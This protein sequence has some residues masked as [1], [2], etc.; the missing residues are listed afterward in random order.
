MYPPDFG[1][2]R[3]NLIPLSVLMRYGARH[4]F[5]ANGASRI[6]F[7]GDGDTDLRNDYVKDEDGNIVFTAYGPDQL[8]NTVK[9]DTGAWNS[10]CSAEQLKR[11]TS[12]IT[13]FRAGKNELVA[14]GLRE[15]IRPPG[16]FL[17]LG[18]KFFSQY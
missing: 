16:N 13:L 10:H 6:Y 17:L 1:N 3:N 7:R 18:Q 8:L 15:S 4:V 11:G 2:N 12:E 5:Y 9:L 14:S